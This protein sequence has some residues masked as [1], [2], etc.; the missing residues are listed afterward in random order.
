[1][2]YGEKTCPAHGEAAKRL[3]KIDSM[4]MPK[5]GERMKYLVING[6]LKPIKSRS[7]PMFEY[8]G[9]K[10]MSVDLNYYFRKQVL[11]PIQR[12]LSSLADLN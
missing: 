5:Y 4:M 11:P 12:V 6:G 1:M 8:L 9:N 3:E 10:G 7:I 2:K